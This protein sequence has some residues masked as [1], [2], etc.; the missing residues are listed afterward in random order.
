MAFCLENVA[1][2]HFQTHFKRKELVKA[3]CVSLVTGALTQDEGDVSLLP[4]KLKVTPDLTG[5]AGSEL[6]FCVYVMILHTFLLSFRKR[7]G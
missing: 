7:C 6:H 5:Q 3:V 4:S 2:R 1:H